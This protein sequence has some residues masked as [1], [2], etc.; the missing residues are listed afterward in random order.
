MFCL[1]H[2]RLRQRA[3]DGF[4]AFQVSRGLHTDRTLPLDIPGPP[5]S[6]APRQAKHDFS[7]YTL[8]PSLR[9]RCLCGLAARLPF[10]SGAGSLR[11]SLRWWFGAGGLRVRCRCGCP[12]V[13][14]LGCGAPCIVVLRSTSCP[15]RG[16]HARRCLRCVRPVRV[17]ASRRRSRPRLHP[18]YPVRLRLRLTC[19]VRWS[20]SL[21]LGILV[22]SAARWRSRLRLSSRS[23]S[24][25]AL[26]IYL[27]IKQILC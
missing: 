6:F 27:Q 23:I 19:L 22:S 26:K 20:S 10:S 7:Q 21:Y 17:S 13:L 3:G 9:H 4:A 1:R 25:L 15:P 11:C 16:P 18:R 12:L 8:V 5:S 24:L 14:P 2:R